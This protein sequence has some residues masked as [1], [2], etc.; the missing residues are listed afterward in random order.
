MR[1]G[2]KSKFKKKKSNSFAKL[3]LFQ[4]TGDNLHKPCPFVSKKRADNRL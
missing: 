3:S 2:K 1:R 4:R